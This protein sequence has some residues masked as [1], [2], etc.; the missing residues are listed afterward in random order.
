MRTSER[1][2][3]RLLNVTGR[4]ICPSGYAYAPGITL[5]KGEPAR[6]S[7]DRGM[8]VIEGVDIGD[9]EAATSIHQHLGKALL[10]DDGIDDEWVASWSHDMGGWSLS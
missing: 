1:K 2:L 5:W 6:R 8:A 3:A 7:S 4:S 10:A 9:V